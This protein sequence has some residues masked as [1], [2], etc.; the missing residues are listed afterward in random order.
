MIY[1][2]L[3]IISKVLL[4]STVCVVFCFCPMNVRAETTEDLFNIYDVSLGG[5]SKPTVETAL[6]EAETQ[7]EEAE[8]KQQEVT[9]TNSAIQSARLQ[10]EMKVEDV[11]ER[12][13]K[14]VNDNMQIKYDIECN[15]YGD[16]EFLLNNDAV[17]KSNMKKANQ[18]LSELDQYGR[19]DYMTVEEVD[20]EKIMSD[21]NNIVS[22]YKEAID[23][24]EMGDVS[25][26]KFPMDVPMYVT[27]EF[28]NRIDPLNPSTTR[29]HSGL[30]LRAKVGTEVQSLFNG[31]VTECGWSDTVGYFVRVEHGKNVRTFYC[32]LSELLCTK[33]QQ[34]SQ[35]DV[36]AKSGATGSR[37][38][39]PHL[40]L[41]LYING[42]AVNPQVL[43]N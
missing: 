22:Q 32:H 25:T 5:V 28:G 13:T 34:V 33:G 40:H 20:I 4:L 12:V 23:V 42:D 21:Y 10:Y 11:N 27:S 7:L 17:Y 35:Y 16:I 8:R 2:P 9:W 38:T 24:H 43:F 36:I 30:D 29:Y 15:I 18:V 6:Q 19:I 39:G 1:S 41:G 14:I 3:K 31:V 26:V 37:C